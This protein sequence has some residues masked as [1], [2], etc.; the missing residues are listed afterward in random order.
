[1]KLFKNSKFIS[2]ICDDFDLKC[3]E[4]VKR[5]DFQSLKRYLD[6]TAKRKEMYELDIS[7]ETIIW[8]HSEVREKKRF[9]SLYQKY[10][11]IAT[12]QEL[13]SFEPLFVSSVPTQFPLCIAG[14]VF[15]NFRELALRFPKLNAS[16]R[17]N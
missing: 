13:A 4:F 14:I 16:C 12:E 9:L 2:K 6:S 11:D 5:Q 15:S 7:K 10:R 8:H 17:A 3:A 1:M